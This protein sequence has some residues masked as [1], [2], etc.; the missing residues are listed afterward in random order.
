MS[1]E[2]VV[3]WLGLGCIVAGVA[4]M[5]MTPTSMIWGFN[6]GAELACGL[7]ACI[8][9][10]FV[11][12]A[13]FL[14]QAKETGILGAITV[15]AMALG[16]LLTSSV[17]WGFLVYG[18]FGD[19]SNLLSSV[20]GIASSA[21]VLGGA[22]VLAILTWRAKVFPRA[23]AVG[24]L[25]ML[26]SMALPWSEWFAFFWGLSYVIMGYCIWTGKLGRPLS[27]QTTAG[28]SG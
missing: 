3:R 25:G 9:M 2:K 8:L 24:L 22:L 5:G 26:A 15:T 13:F 20:T 10:S 19:E 11:T 16:N 12:F 6:S 28:L 18:E 17:L 23:A 7:T 27:A 1:W 4:R 14:V 21:G